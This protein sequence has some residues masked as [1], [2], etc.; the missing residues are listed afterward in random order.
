M[1]VMAKSEYHSLLQGPRVI[2][3]NMELFKHFCHKIDIQIALIRSQVLFSLDVKFQDTLSMLLFH[4]SKFLNNMIWRDN[5]TTN[6]MKNGIPV[7]YNFI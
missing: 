2:T 1:A 3:Q 7:R 5:S 4:I 6:Y